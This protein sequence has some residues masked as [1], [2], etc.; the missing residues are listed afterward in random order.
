MILLKDDESG[1]TMSDNLIEAEV[2]TFMIAGHE[3][4]SVALTWT[5]YLLAKHPEIQGKVCYV[6]QYTGLSLS[7]TL[8]CTSG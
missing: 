5:F 7:V 1:K 4:T 2:H 8:A 3:T 6:M